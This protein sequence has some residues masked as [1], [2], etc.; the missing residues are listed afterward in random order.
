MTHNFSVSILHSRS[1]RLLLLPEFS[2]YY[3]HPTFKTIQSRAAKDSNLY[4]KKAFFPTETSQPDNQKKREIRMPKT[5]ASTNINNDDVIALQKQQQTK[6]IRHPCYFSPIQCLLT[7]PEDQMRTF[8]KTHN[9][10]ID[11]RFMSSLPQRNK[12]MSRVKQ[13]DDRHNLFGAGLFRL[14][15]FEK[16]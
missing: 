6:S 16:Y 7:I 5:T 2:S 4:I 8:V 15:P 3:K 1:K 13:H 14:S 10:V 12:V 11:T 9:N